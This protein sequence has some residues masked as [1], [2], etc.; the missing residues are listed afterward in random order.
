MGSTASE[1]ATPLG[2]LVEGD[3]R[4]GGSL[5]AALPGY[6]ERPAQIEMA[7]RVAQAVETGEH[8]ILEA[9][10]GVGKALDVETPI[11]TL[12]GWKRMGDLV[13]GDMVFDEAGQPTRV[14]AAFDTLYERPCYEVVFSDGSSLVADAEHQWASYTCTDRE[15]A[16]RTRSPVYA[17][18]N[19]VTPEKLVS[20]DLLIAASQD[21]ES[22]SIAGATK[23]LDGHHWSGFQAAKTMAPTNPGV[24]SVHS[25]RQELLTAV[26]ARL[27]KDLSEQSRSG[28]TYTVVTTEQMAA[29]LTKHTTKRANYAI[30]VAGTL[31]LPGV[32]LP[33]HPYF[34]GVWL[35]DGSSYSNQITTADPDLIPF[36][37]Q[38]GYTVRRIKSHPYRYA[39]DDENGKA[40]SRWQPGMT[41]RL[42]AL[43]VRLNKHIPA[44]YLR[45]SEEQRRALLAGLLDSDGTVN[46]VGAIEFTTTSPQLAGDVNEL[47]CS[48]GFRPSVRSGRARLYGKDCGPK[49]TLQLTTDKQVFQLPRKVATH[50]ERLRNYTPERNRFRYV[51]DVR[52]VVSR[53]VR[54]IQVEA[55]SHLYLAGRAMIPTHN[56]LAYLLPI[57]RS[58]KVALV[59]TANKALQEQLFYKDIPFVQQRIEPFT[60]AL[61]KG[62]GN[63]LCLDLLEEERPFQA[64]T[65]QTAFARM[66][67]LLGDY[68]KWDGDLDLLPMALA[69]DTRSRLAADNERCA[70]RACAFY[71]DCYVREMREVAR[72]ARVIV[73]NHTLLLL[74]AAMGGFLLPERDLIVI[75]E[76]HH[77]EEE[78]TRAFTITVTPGR[79]RSLLAQQ[80]LQQNSDPATQQRVATASAEAWD[81]LARSGRPDALGRQRLTQPIEEGLR[82]AGALSD[83]ATSL[84]ERRPL[85]LDEKEDMLYDKLV[86]RARV[87]AADTRIAFGQE[88][89]EERV[90]YAEQSAA[91]RGRNG[92]PAQSVSAAPLEVTE[93]LRDKLFDRIPVIATSAT[94]A[95][96]GDF[97]F[98][99][100]RVGLLGAQEATLPYAFDYRD[101]ALLYVPR[102]RYE[103]AYGAAGTAYLDELAGEMARLIEASRGRA[104]L[105]FSSQRALQHVLKQLE[106]G[107]AGSQYTFLVQGEGL[108]RI[109]LTRQFRQRERA[110][111]F[112][113][114]SFWEGVDVVGQA[115]SLVVIDKLPFD[116]PDD[117]VNEARVSAM[118][119]AG[120]NWF[121]GYALPMAILRLKQ[122]IGRL[123]RT[124]DDRGVMAILDKRLHTKSYGAETLRA[125]PPATRTADIAAVRHFF[126]E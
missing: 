48:L 122:G 82:L 61:V 58:G 20:I 33:I 22:L 12:D 96:G 23:L 41:G 32:D 103:P 21:T 108:S 117:P 53:P 92:Q 73:V 105:L 19:I 99:R 66:E 40:V 25:P 35:G 39:V 124:K 126:E 119:Q 55:A 42:R 79:V 57:V 106:Y 110:V 86:K 62:M 68:G 49:W 1:H 56:S 94:L 9:P 64:Y 77:L 16:G 50:K 97:S 71:Q 72:Q 65:R 85:T 125:L 81:A 76:A 78:A 115:L 27:T 67:E 93:L 87:L 112:G 121:G 14:V 52:S 84:Q 24:R 34:F 102:M 8:L 74:D 46:H 7:R 69:L 89:K 113:L 104:F 37:E 10:T 83:L 13:I 116:P 5:S 6:E 54:C 26:Q 118:K 60:A 45:A 101:H 15:W 107:P 98:F 111:L 30:A 91:R 75:D 18:K 3:L 38:L 59:S 63:Y 36:I 70:W 2:E 95:V 100:S 29:T 120:Q 80:R 90:Y 44:I 31:S 123:L 4:E 43:G 109:E 114:K 47:V 88:A 11:P 51:T 28:R 17:A